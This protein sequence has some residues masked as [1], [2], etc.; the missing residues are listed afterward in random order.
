[1]KTYVAWLLLLLITV[2][3]ISGCT[4]DTS[5]KSKESMEQQYLPNRGQIIA[6]LGNAW[7]YFELDGVLYLYR[8]ETR[9]GGYSYE[10][11][12]AVPEPVSST[13]KEHYQKYGD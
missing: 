6:K 10:C 5:G 11:I 3:P 2:T 9:I 1:M 7:V 8:N 4:L 13:L 12:S